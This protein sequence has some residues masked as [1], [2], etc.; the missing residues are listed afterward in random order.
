M[1]TD[2][3][4]FMAEA[5]ER[6]ME[7]TP[8][9]WESFPSLCASQADVEPLLEMLELLQS[10]F[11]APYVRCV[12]PTEKL[13]RIARAAREKS[14]AGDKNGKAALGDLDVFLCCLTEADIPTLANMVRWASG[15][16]RRLEERASLRD[17]TS[18]AR[19]G[20]DALYT[21]ARAAR[22]KK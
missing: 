18:I 1:S 19:D 13:N 6:L 3:E 5:K 20:Y 2:L 9:Q 14:G 16:F 12:V 22:E 7:P 11:K 21:L 4:Q 10:K 17:A 8:F 15:E